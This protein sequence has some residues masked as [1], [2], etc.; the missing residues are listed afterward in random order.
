MEKY[1]AVDE[2]ITKITAVFGGKV[3]KAYVAVALAVIPILI[4]L[5]G[6]VGHLLM[7]ELYSVKIIK[8][9]FFFNINCFKRLIKEHFMCSDMV[10]FIY[11]MYKSIKAIESEEKADDSQWLTYWL[12]F[13]L[14]K[15]P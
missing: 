8:I 7:Y 15:V 1:P 14:F 11:P 9:E 3:D 4:V 13:S 5:V 6:G 10:G 2:P 12:I